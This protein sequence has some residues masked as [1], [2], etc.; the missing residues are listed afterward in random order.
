MNTTKLLMG[1]AALCTS[2]FA[3]TAA[4]GPAQAMDVTVRA[5]L[6]EEVPQTTVKIAD[7]QLASE[8]GKK[9]LRRR[10]GLA[11]SRVCEPLFEGRNTRDHSGCLRTAWSGARPQMARVISAAERY[12]KAGGASVALASIAVSADGR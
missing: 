12:A 8:H 3:L 2:G 10:V 9:V 5:A 6:P 11:V 4:A 1:A 7:L